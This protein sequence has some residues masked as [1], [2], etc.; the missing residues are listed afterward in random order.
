MNP[1]TPGKYMTTFENPLIDLIFQ[2]K[3]ST[4]L[5]CM[6]IKGPGIGIFLNISSPSFINFSFLRPNPVF[7]SS[8]EFVC[9][10]KF[11]NKETGW[12][13]AFSSREY[14]RIRPGL[15][16]PYSLHNRATW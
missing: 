2:Q 15:V 3:S 14:D 1:V 7:Y 10:I 4:S 13:R 6:I 5:I 12:H 8:V 11:L 9:R 16:G